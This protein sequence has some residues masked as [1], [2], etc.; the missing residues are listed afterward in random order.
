MP[1]IRVNDINMYYEIHGAGNPLLLIGGLGIDLSE[2]ESISSWLA[3]KYRV[4]TF[5]NRGAGRTDKPDTPYSIEMM[6]RDTEEL[7]NAL[8]IER[9]SVLGI[10]LGGRIALELALQH[11]E[12]VEKLLLVSTSARVRGTRKRRWRLRLLSLLSSIPAFR[13]KYPQPRYAF[14]RQFQAST[15]YN[16]TD[17]LH[18]LQMPTAIMHGKKDKSASYALAEE[19]HAGIRGS[20]I[21]TFKGGHIFFFMG[22]RQRFLDTTAEFINK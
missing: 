2:L 3:Q 22:E 11:P 8:G 20:Q 17:R 18:K 21:F 10:S 4:L 7:L 15:N 1:T 19:M 16:C 6:A 13:S 9:V 14:L 12:K 5:D